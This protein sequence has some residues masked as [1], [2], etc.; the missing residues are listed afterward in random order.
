MIESGHISPWDEN[1]NDRIA[2]TLDIKKELQLVKPYS[3]EEYALCFEV[4]QD[5]ERPL[6]ERE[7]YLLARFGR[8]YVDAPEGFHK[9]LDDIEQRMAA[10]VG[11]F[12]L[13]QKSPTFVFI[14]RLASADLIYRT[15]VDSFGYANGKLGI[16]ISSMISTALDKNNNYELAPEVSSDFVDVQP[17]SLFIA[18]GT[19]SPNRIGDARTYTLDPEKPFYHEGDTYPICF[20]IEEISK[21]QRKNLHWAEHVEN[22]MGAWN[23]G[24]INYPVAHK[25]ILDSALEFRNRPAGPTSSF[26]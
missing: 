14:A 22:M 2:S 15:C 23:T 19:T 7:R 24:L 9:Q 5:T 20:G 16:G 18:E 6:S 3:I 25:K 13:V 4:A 21:W 17:S 8:E 12:V 11:E 10:H 1:S 26:L